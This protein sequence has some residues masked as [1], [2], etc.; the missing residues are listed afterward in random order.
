MEALA[1]WLA[2][3]LVIS[4]IGNALTTCVAWTSAENL[5][6]WLATPAT[7][8]DE[9]ARYAHRAAA[10]LQELAAEERSAAA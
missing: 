2:I 9:L 10:R 7:E 3:V 4:L 8:D 6:R 5:R 1:T